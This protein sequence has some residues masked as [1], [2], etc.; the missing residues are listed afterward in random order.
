[1]LNKRQEI[2]FHFL[3]KKFSLSQRK[4]LKAFIKSLFKEE[5]TVL[6][7]VDYIFCSDEFLLGLNKQFL[8]HSFYTDILSFNL[9]GGKG[10]LQGEI[11]ISPIRV[12][13]NAHLFKVSFREELHRVIFHGA[14]HFCGYKDKTKKDTA[15]M[16][17]KESQYLDLYRQ[18]I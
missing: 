3:F 4:H 12:R 14:L 2:S 16:R 11:Y 10:P 5:K 6:G 13:E 8:G 18:F 9:T 17:E 15:V 1:M 7:H